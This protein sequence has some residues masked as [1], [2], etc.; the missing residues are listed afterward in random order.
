MSI[1]MLSCKEPAIAHKEI[2]LE[3]DW[4]V[5][6]S[7]SVQQTGREISS[8]EFM[9]E[10]SYGTNVPSTVLAA[11][12]RNN[13]Y[14][15]I[16]VGDNFDNIPGEPFQRSW[17]YR[18]TFTAQ[19]SLNTTSR[20]IFEG[21]NYRANVWLNGQMVADAD[22]MEG[23]FRIFDLDISRE[24]MNGDNVLAVEVIPPN[25]QELT[26]GFV[27]WNPWPADNNLGIWRPVKLVQS[28]A[29]SIQ[30][31]YVKPK[32][33]T[34]TLDD[35]AIEI[36]ATLRNYSNETVE[37]SFV[38]EFEN[39]GIQKPYSIKPNSSVKVLL[40]PEEHAE[41]NIDNP[42]IWWP[43][44]LGDPNLYQ[45]Q[46]TAIIGR[47]L[48][49]Q[50]S[51][52]FGIRSIEDYIN[53]RGHRG[54]KINGHKILIKGGGWVDDV[55]LDDSDDKVEAQIQYVKN[56][57]MN[58]IRLE[59]F[60]GKNKRIYDLADEN[61]ILVMIGWSCQWEWE[62]Y[63]GRP[64]DDT[65][66]SIFT[67][68]DVDLHSR[69]YMDQVRWLRNHPSVFLW[70]FGSDK[71]VIPELE[72]KLINFIAAE[73]GT[74]PTLG[75]CK[76]QTS[77]LSGFTAVK[78][79][80]P[81]KYVTPNY[82]YLDT[83]NGG[84][85]GFNTETGPGC[86]P[87]PLESIKKM[88]PED[89]LWPMNEI[90][91]YHTGR[92]EFAT[93]KDWIK[94]F[95]ARYGPAKN[96][97]EFAFN[98]QLSNYEAI[99]AMFE[100]FAVNKHNATGVIQW[101]LNSALPNMLWQVY[102]WYLMPTGAFYGTMHANEPVNLLYHYGDKGIYLTNELHTAQKDLKA[103]IK[104]LDL[105]SKIILAKEIDAEVGENTAS[106]I[107]DASSLPGTTSVYFLDLKLKDRQGDL[108]SENF[109]WLSSKEDV[110]D[111][112]NTEWHLTPNKQYADFSSLDKLPKAQV[113]VTHKFEENENKQSI[114]VSLTNNSNKLAF[115]IE[116]VMSDQS[117]GATVLPTFWEDNYISL[118][119]GETKKMNGYVYKKDLKGAPGF[120]YKGFNVN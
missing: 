18:K 52:R 16:Y 39:I 74:R 49:D 106:K 56:M 24:L 112:E 59:G 40:S 110:L 111:F 76:Y 50:K 66:M 60:W 71:L 95:N 38:C 98:A 9:L 96:V 45:L 77:E 10:K 101:M 70:V 51:T 114:Q 7:A 41:L 102:D 64:E 73:D 108:V 104:I 19:N 92:N 118:L 90:W 2:E 32:L 113:D 5:F 120:R 83:E 36:S 88:I 42:R 23:C 48:S 27:D 79:L 12:V 105:N 11:L 80:G 86:Q 21:I 14:S 1:S 35:A 81:Y 33:N 67:P 29:V 72:Q 55:L 26:I 69:S 85:F 61:G 107:F 20:L 13:V 53:H 75:A 57:N 93:F 119:P 44:N 37:G 89:R 103:E 100:A 30:N 115:F 43:N 91:D 4:S 109:Y 46:A 87:P 15:D 65:Y 116:L 62:G 6:S 94:P 68:E 84:A 58:T 8:E 17:W 54:Y 31:L 97:E 78:M 82:W 34:E 47:E 25:D 22:T 117:T 3:M 63:C 99:R 28:G